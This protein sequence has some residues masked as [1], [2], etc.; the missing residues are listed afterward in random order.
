MSYMFALMK[1]TARA[2][3]T[4]AALATTAGAQDFAAPTS[5]VILTISGSIAKTNGDSMLKLDVAQF[6]AL[7]QHEFS[8]STTWT[9]G[10]SSFEG[11][12]LKDLIAE[13]GATGS[14]IEL[15]ALN[16]YKITIPTADI[17]DDGPLLAYK[18]DGKTMSLREKGPIWLVYPYDANSDY[19]TEQTYT[20]SIW[21][22]ARIKFAD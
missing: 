22:L 14:E 10:T 18:M 19:R 3:A 7:P 13:V 2:A 5:A 12:L 17:R 1:S 9:E 16:D 20:R 15:S 4:F 6:A 21:Q 8:T 11:V